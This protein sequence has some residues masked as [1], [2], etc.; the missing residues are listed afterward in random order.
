MANRRFPPETRL[1]RRQVILGRNQ[2]DAP[3][4]Y[5]RTGLQT[6]ECEL[7]AGRIRG[8]AVHIGAR[9]AAL[10]SSGEVLVSGTMRDVVA[11]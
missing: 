6:G 11:G 3:V 7:D 9:V 4:I 2:K 5:L 8:I 1:V 10:A